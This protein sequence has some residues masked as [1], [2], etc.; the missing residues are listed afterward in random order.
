VLT[1]PTKRTISDDAR[2]LFS[3][4]NR[5]INIHYG[6][7]YEGAARRNLPNPTLGLGGNA[8]VA[9]GQIR[10]RSTDESQVKG[11]SDMIA[12]G[13]SDA[14]VFFPILF[15]EPPDY[16]D[17]L[18]ILFPQAASVTGKPGVGDWHNGG[19]NMVFCDGHVAYARQ[20]EWS[21]AS[22]FA[23]QRWNNDHKPHPELW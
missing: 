7:N 8:L 13:D 17:L 1:C 6:Y 2:E 9:G 23:R 20:S 11:P 18:H 19:A 12:V 16:E 10:F 4:S 5:A 15:P 14:N 22:N 3:F 21:E